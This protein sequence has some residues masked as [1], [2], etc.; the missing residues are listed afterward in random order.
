MKS[1]AFL[2]T[3][4]GL[5]CASSAFT[6]APQPRAVAT[7][8]KTQANM[9]V[10]MTGG[11]IAN[12]PPVASI[13]S[14]FGFVALWELTDPERKNF[15]MGGKAAVAPAPAPAPVVEEPVAEE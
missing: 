7:S 13:Y 3:L 14:L 2:I 9:F 4:L 8:S 6:T 12:V 10:D 11:D 1:F 15:K 5:I